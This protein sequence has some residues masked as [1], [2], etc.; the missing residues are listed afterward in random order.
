MEWEVELINKQI[1]ELYGPIA[2]LIR[3]SNLRIELLCFQLGRK[4]IFPEEM[5]TFDELPENEQKLWA[6]FVDTYKIPCQMKIVDILRKNYH[7]IY[8]S[9]IPPC[10]DTFVK[11]AIGW[12]LLD[13]QKRNG[14]FNYY[15]Y[16]FSY[17]YPHEFDHYIFSTL[18]TL[19][20]RKQDL[21][22]IKNQSADIY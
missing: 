20:N 16:C 11:Y 2:E 9:E 7:L 22:A 15:K 6:H 4:H 1:S 3:E 10:Y 8:N 14:V 18:K 12:E 21:M 5:Q 17:N 13:N 19:Q